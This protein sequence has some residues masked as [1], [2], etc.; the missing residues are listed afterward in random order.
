MT[1][2][3][4]FDV[5]G[6]MI[7]VPHQLLKPTDKTI[8]ALKEFQKQGNYIVVASARGVKPECLDEIPFDGFIGCD[9]GYIEFHQEV[10]LNNVFSVKDLN[11][12]NSVYEA[13]NGQYIISERAT[14]YFSD[15]DGELIKKHLRLY[16]GTDKLPEEYNDDWRFQNIKANTVTALF[17]NAKDLH[18]ALDMLPKEW[19]INAYDTGHIRMDVHPQGYTKGTACE[20]L[21]QKLNIPKENT[22]AFGDGENDLEMIDFCRVGVAMGNAC[23]VLK[24]KANTIQ[25][26]TVVIAFIGSLFVIKP[27]IHFVSN[28]NSFIGVLGAMGAGIA[29]TCVR[30]LGQQGVAGA[31]IVFFFS[32]FSCLS[33]VPY[34]IFHFQPMTL[35]Q[36]GCLLMAGLMAAGGQFSITN[37]YTY[38]PA[39]EISI[40]DYTQVI[41][42]ALLGFFLLNQV[43]DVYSVIGYIIIIGVA[44]WNFMKQK[45]CV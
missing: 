37:A 13:T 16:N 22:Y 45:R 12:Q 32:L 24:E 8:H 5:D 10:L 40:Y 42:A 36:I 19:S 34:L 39:K 4:F 26:V 30:K 6:T 17:Y 20:Y 9:G 14:S 35:Q 44:F 38:A 41:F 2:I 1:K 33:V 28:I 29:Y 15:V 18:E 25:K 3:A 7:N 31:K 11:L 21:Y 23:D 43:P 27:S